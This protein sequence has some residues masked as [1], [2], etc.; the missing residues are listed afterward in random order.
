MKIMYTLEQVS[1]SAGRA[2]IF[3]VFVVLLVAVSIWLGV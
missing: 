3:I 1:L 2:V